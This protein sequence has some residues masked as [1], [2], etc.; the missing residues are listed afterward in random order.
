MVPVMVMEAGRSFASKMILL[1]PQFL[2]SMEQFTCMETPL[3]F[4]PT[5]FSLSSTDVRYCDSVYS[6]PASAEGQGLCLQD[7]QTPGQASCTLQ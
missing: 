6:V 7:E 4:F 1:L 2:Q 5:I 3:S